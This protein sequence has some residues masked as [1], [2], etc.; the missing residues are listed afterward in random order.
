MEVAEAANC[1]A[2]ADLDWEEEDES[3]ENTIWAKMATKMIALQALLCSSLIAVGCSQS[4]VHIFLLS[5]SIPFCSG[6]EYLSPSIV[7]I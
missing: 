5:T 3:Q 2:A 4:V 1:D 7:Q 6:T